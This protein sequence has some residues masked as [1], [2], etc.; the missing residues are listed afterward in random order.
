MAPWHSFSI[1]L[2]AISLFAQTAV[3]VVS[4]NYTAALRNCS[5]A[6]KYPVASLSKTNFVRIMADLEPGSNETHG[7][8]TRSEGNPPDTIFGLTMCY[9][10]SNW[11]QC[12]KCLRAA[13]ASMP[14][15]CPFSRHMK[16]CHKACIL[17][18][19]NE[20]FFSIADLSGAMESYTQTGANVTNMV[21]MNTTRLTLMHRLSR[22]AADSTLRLA[23]ESMEFNDSDGSS[24]MIFGLAQCT[25][26]LNASECNRCLTYFVAKLSSSRLNHTYGAVKG[27]SC[28][29]VYQIGKDL[30]ITI[31]PAPPPTSPQ[32]EAATSPPPCHG[33]KAEH[34]VS[35]SVGSLV[36]VITLVIVA[37]HFWQNR[38]NDMTLGI[39]LGDVSD[40]EQQEVNFE[41]GAV[42]QRFHYRDLAVATNYFSDKVKL[43][44][45]G[46][47]SVYHGYLQDMDLHVAIKRVS[48]KSNQGRKEYESEVKII[49]RL[50]HRNLVELIGWYHRGDELLLVYELMPNG[51]L[52]THIHNPD[53]VLPWTIRHDI[54]LGIGSALLYLHQDCQQC[55]LHRDIKPSNIMLDAVFNAKLGDFGLARLVDHGRGSHT[56]VVAGTLGYLDPECMVTGGACI[57]SDVYS[58]GVVLLEIACGQP[59]II[60]VTKG[61]NTHLV[62]WVWEFYNSG[63]ILDAAD[64]RLDGAF[65]NGEMERVMVTALWCA[66]PDRT[67]RPTIREAVNVLRLER[68]LPILPLKMPVATFVPSQLDQ[69]QTKSDTATGGRIITW[70]TTGSISATETSSLLR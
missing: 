20:S 28:Y 39:E 53:K 9:A 46:F 44:D 19:S 67:Q 56:T 17:R 62:Q 2:I 50:R 26:D 1:L 69:M 43:G 11:D 52:D 60:E 35:V 66:H 6:G 63:K 70:I 25:R 3:V 12:Q 16:A 29:I 42:P 36:L 13:I 10:D 23:N 18:Y 45:G 24:R 57:E 54:V 59:P 5:I 68:Q 65:S 47:G 8:T 49:S 64:T 14:E 55:I 32:Q 61:T 37:W 41:K 48:K 51:S 34:V 30:G 22:K 40:G 58:F 27:Y 4:Q 31:P 38:S 7:F 33:P 15:T 21:R